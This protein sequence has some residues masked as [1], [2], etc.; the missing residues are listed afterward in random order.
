MPAYFSLQA[1]FNR[2]D[3]HPA[4]VRDFYNHLFKCDL[5]FKSGFLDAQGLSF[6]EIVDWNQ[7]KLE[8]NF[9]LGMDEH[10]SNDYKQIL[11]DFCEFSEVRGYWLNN[12][13]SDDEFT[14]SIIV[15]ESELV[16][17]YATNPLTTNEEIK[18][19]ETLAIS[20]WDFDAMQSIHASWESGFGALSPAQNKGLPIADPF[21][22]VPEE[23]AKMFPKG[24]FIQTEISRNGVFLKEQ[25]PSLQKKLWSAFSHIVRFFKYCF[26]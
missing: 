3:I 8:N 2:K 10:H 22:I 26:K 21:V 1:V 12:Y 18:K 6:A 19:L 9:R 5:K 13:P 4:F 7:H 16:E 15:P 23:Y 14:F 20:M 11:F 25:P 24:I 17:S